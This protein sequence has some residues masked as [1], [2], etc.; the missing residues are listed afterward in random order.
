MRSSFF[1]VDVSNLLYFNVIVELEYRHKINLCDIVYQY[2]IMFKLLISL[3][4]SKN[5]DDHRL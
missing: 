5:I 3:C 4:Y 1:Y 2:L